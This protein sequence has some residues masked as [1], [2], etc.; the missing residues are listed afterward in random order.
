[1]GILDNFSLFKTD[2]DASTQANTTNTST[3]VAAQT[4]GVA[5][6]QATNVSVSTTDQN[7]IQKAFD[8]AAGNDASNGINYSGLLKSTG[9]IFGA[10]ISSQDKAISTV[11]SASNDQAKSVQSSLLSAYTNGASDKTSTLDNRTVTI[12]VLALAGAA[13]IY[14][15]NKRAG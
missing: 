11:L 6:Q 5:L 3:P 7:A 9:D 2:K 1:M 8:F 15:Y 4:G 14:F 12:I 13:S 10:V